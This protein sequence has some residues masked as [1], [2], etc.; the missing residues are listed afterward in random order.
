MAD[1]A[2]CKQTGEGFAYIQMP[3]FLHGAGEEAG[4]KQVQNGVFN[5]ANILVNSQPAVSGITH[6]GGGGLW[7]RKARK[8]PGAINKR[9][10]RVGFSGGRL[11]A[12]RAV[13]ML[14]RG[15]MV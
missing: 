3:G 5:P 15:V 11:A 13:H 8:I 14:P 1:H 2:L 4:I 6:R 9:I 10:K 12:F 7:G